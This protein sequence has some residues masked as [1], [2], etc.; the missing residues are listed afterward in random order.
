MILSN[1]D[2]WQDMELL[3]KQF[4]NRLVVY[5]YG[6]LSS[7]DEASDVVS[8]VMESIWKDWQSDTPR[9][10]DPSSALLYS[11]VRNRCLDI[12]RHTK[13]HDRYSTLVLA[14]AEMTTEMDVD[15]F[16]ERISRLQRAI[17]ALP[18]KD[19]EVLKCTY[20][21]QLTYKETAELLDISENSVHKRMLRVFRTLRE[22]TK[23]IMAWLILALNNLI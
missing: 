15:A 22:T 21:K 10:T 5:A 20:F 18:Q 17:A 6:F 12:L 13:A 2:K 4:Y 23:I 16:E 9:L 1:T 3:Y 8:G 14:T 19:R 11:L 7:K